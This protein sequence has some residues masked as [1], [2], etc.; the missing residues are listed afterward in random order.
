MSTCVCTCAQVDAGL[1]PAALAIA[2]C[3][4]RPFMASTIVGATSLAQ[5]N[6]N[7]AGLRAS[8]KE[9]PWPAYQQAES[10]PG[11]AFGQTGPSR[12]SR[13]LFS[14]TDTGFGV[15]WTDDLEDG[16]NDILARYPDPWRMLV[17]DG[18]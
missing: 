3:E 8:R 6:E 11:L 18:G 12:P 16:V 17:R 2:F 10:R 1:S 13:P 5:L 15:E 14:S 4:S 7:L 9:P